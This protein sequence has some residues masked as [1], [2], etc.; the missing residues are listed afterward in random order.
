MFEAWKFDLNA[1]GSGPQCSN[2]TLD[3]KS[4]FNPTIRN[5]SCQGITNSFL[6]NSQLCNFICSL[7]SG[8][9]L[10][11]FKPSGIP[12]TGQLAP[13]NM[14]G[15]H[16]TIFRF[17]PGIYECYMY[18]IFRIISNSV[19]T[20]TRHLDSQ[21]LLSFFTFAASKLM[22]G[23]PLSTFSSSNIIFRIFC[24]TSLSSLL[25]LPVASSMPKVCTVQPIYR[26]ETEPV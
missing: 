24:L 13:R 10:I 25:V 7:I 2:S 15:N 14:E 17:N 20:K 26:I 1:Q 11:F 3:F 5:I 16:N 9:C 22:N 8:F 18:L 23:A 6:C 4:Y 21:A 12:A 19:R